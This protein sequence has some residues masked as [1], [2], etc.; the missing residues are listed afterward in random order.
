MTA[1]GYISIALAG[2]LFENEHL[3]HSSIHGLC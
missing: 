2:Q 3:R 1:K